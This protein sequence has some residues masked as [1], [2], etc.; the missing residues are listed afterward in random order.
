MRVGS[1]KNRFSGNGVSLQA[2]KSR[3]P[4]AFYLS[5]AEPPILTCVHRVVLVSFPFIYFAFR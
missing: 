5:K 1:S 3:G 4:N 2:V